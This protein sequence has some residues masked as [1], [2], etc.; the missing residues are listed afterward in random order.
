MVLSPPLLSEGLLWLGRGSNPPLFLV[1]TVPYL[2]GKGHM[3]GGVDLTQTKHICVAG[4]VEWSL[5]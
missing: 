5:Q 4:R 2:R 3:G 1:R